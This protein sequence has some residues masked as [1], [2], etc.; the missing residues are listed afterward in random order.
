MLI[1]MYGIT[2]T[3][4]HVTYRPIVEQDLKT[5]SSPIGQAIPDLTTYVLD[6]ALQ[7]LPAG[8]TGEMY[9]AGPGLARGYFGR[10]GLTS[11]RFIADPFEPGERM[12]RTGDLGRWTESGDLEYFGRAD[13]QVKIRGFRIELGEI[14]AA[15]VAVP[16]VSQCT[17]QVRGEES[18][19]QLIAYLVSK[20]GQQIPLSLIH[21]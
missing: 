3:T 5:D 19:K 10:T 20:D 9:V 11:E 2:E 14:E 21:I 17:V 8:I 13:Q 1:N 12:Y 16:G 6:A 7:P 18:A 15:L 4:V